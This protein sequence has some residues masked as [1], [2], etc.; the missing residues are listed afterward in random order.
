MVLS[1]SLP[2]ITFV[3]W[4]VTISLLA[5]GYAVIAI[6]V[7][8]LR[9]QWTNPQQ[10]RRRGA[11]SRAKSRLANMTTSD[12]LQGVFFGYIADKWEGAE[13]GMTTSDACRQ[14]LDNRVPKPLLDAVRTVLESLDAA[15]YAGLDIRSLDE[16]KQT[17]A[18]LLRQLEATGK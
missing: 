9:Y 5:G 14:L 6:G 16:F 7:L 4:A 15:K 18:V 2:P 3:Q 8:L 11:L 13:Q 17:A 1:E 10:L 12:E